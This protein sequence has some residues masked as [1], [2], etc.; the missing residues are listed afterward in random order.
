MLCVESGY[1]EGAVMAIYMIGY[2]LNKAGKNYNGLIERIKEISNGYW[3]HLDSTW[4]IGSAGTAGT[5]RD[6]LYP[7][8][9]GDDELVVVLLAR[10][11]DWA[12]AGIKE[13]GAKWLKENL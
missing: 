12:S 11:G 3:H 10:Q 1:M 8:L 7:Y 5:I 9:D 2:D 4:L 6:A 13:A